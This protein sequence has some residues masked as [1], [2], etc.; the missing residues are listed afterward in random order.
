MLRVFLGRR[1]LAVFV[2]LALAL[3][4]S[5][6]AAVVPTGFYDQLVASGMGLISNFDFLPDG[7]VLAVE[8]TSAKVWLID[9]SG[10]TPTDTVGVIPEVQGSSNEAGLIG[11]AIDPRWPAKPYIY[12]DYNSIASPN[13]K[14]TRYALTGDLDGTQG[15]GLLLDSASRHDI[16]ADLPDDF[17]LHN[18]GTLL[19]RDDGTLF[20]SVGDDNVPCSAQDL[21]A[22][23]GKILR[24]SVLGVPDGP[25]FAPDYQTLMPPDNPY[26]GDPDPRKR[27]VWA[28]GLRN[29]WTYDYDS[30][31][32]TMVIADVGNDLYEEIDVTTEPARNFG[33]PLYEGPFR[34]DYAL[35]TY[36]DT[37]TLTAPAWSYPHPAEFGPAA[38]ILGGL[39][40]PMPNA[41][42]QFPG[43][44]MGNVFC[45][46]LY[47]GVLRRLV[48]A[49]GTCEIAPPVPGQPTVDG[50]AT[51]LNYATRMRYGPDGALWYTEQGEMRRIALEDQVGV[52]QFA[53][54]GPPSLHA[55]PTPAVSQVRLS[56]RL[57]TAGPATLFVTDARGRL[58][59]RL[60]QDDAATAGDHVASWDGMDD[61]GVRVPAGVY[62]GAL[63]TARHTETRRLVM[64]GGR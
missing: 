32:G 52:G 31:T 54:S 39:V 30:Q 1:A 24:L 12:V 63:R 8:R 45:F 29:P 36:P 41:H 2:P 4:V 7:R 15:T 26:A 9:P 40:R 53:T 20:V 50:W 56:Y 42:A 55:F 37:L 13:V 46:D 22:M 51:G 57:P 61:R 27:L 6:H 23:R 17:P 19:F 49:D 34:L 16:L 35:C 47:E 11:I 18:G 21:D 3:A 64:L 58:V 59:R 38:I 44:Y 28:F 33:W 48:C 43:E 60:V 10:L 62:F 25:G 5:A 14:V